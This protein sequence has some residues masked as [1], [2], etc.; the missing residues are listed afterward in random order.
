[1]F[2][3]RSVRVNKTYW[4]VSK[5]VSKNYIRKY[6]DNVI[7]VYP[8]FI[9]HIISQYRSWSE[10]NSPFCIYFYLFSFNIRHIHWRDLSLHNFVRFHC[11][12]LFLIPWKLTSSMFASE[13]R[14]HVE[15]LFDQTICTFGDSSQNHFCVD[16]DF[17]INR[18][19]RRLSRSLVIM[20]FVR[21][22]Y[23][24]L[25]FQQSEIKK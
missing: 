5:S 8:H 19:F 6:V 7:I 15:I 2:I 24:N 20:Q 11:F 14:Y 4:N 23:Y 25:F 3:L 10:V 9:L 21:N 16:E 17:V 1:M 18:T 12:F 13:T 22:F